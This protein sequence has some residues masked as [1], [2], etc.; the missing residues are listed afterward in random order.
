[1]S[2]IAPRLTGAVVLDLFAGTG[3]LGLEAVS[4]GAASALFVERATSALD[5]I[6]RNI[7]MLG[8]ADRTR[9][10]RG[11]AIRFVGDLG[12]KAYDIALA[13]PPYAEDYAERLVQAFRRVPFATLLAVEHAAT[14]RLDGDDTRRYGETAITFCHAP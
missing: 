7:D 9:I 12:A 10:V 8:V 1:M 14:V 4:R 5:L 13:D 6:R 3:A 11:D 2:I